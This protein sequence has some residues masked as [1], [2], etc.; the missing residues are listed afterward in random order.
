MQ[1]LAVRILISHGTDLCGNSST[2]GLKL[3][4]VDHT[5]MKQTLQRFYNT[6]ILSKGK[7]N[8]D[9]K[10]SFLIRYYCILKSKTKQHLFKHK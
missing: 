10:M 5:E 2:S 3:N 9:F 7:R 6:Y 4:K 8:T 1:K